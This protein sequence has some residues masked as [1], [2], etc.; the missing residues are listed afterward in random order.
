LDFTRRDESTYEQ[1]FIN[2]VINRTLD[3]V[4]NEIHVNKVKL[5]KDLSQNLPQ[6]NGNHH[7]L[8]QVFLNI[9]LNAIQA[10]PDGG[11]LTVKSYIDNSAIKIDICDTGEGISSENKEKIFDP[12][13]TTKV[14]GEGTGLGLSVSYGIIKQHHGDILVESELGQ[15]SKFS[16]ILPVSKSEQFKRGY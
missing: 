8:Q 5:E 1:I 10:M 3:F 6:I 16:I 2:D 12:F 4:A 7:N 11:V 9:F 14:V 13:F 15:G